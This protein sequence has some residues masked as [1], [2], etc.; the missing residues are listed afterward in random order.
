MTTNKGIT[1]VSKIGAKSRRLEVSS[2]DK[3][4]T[5]ATGLCAAEYILVLLPG[6]LSRPGEAVTA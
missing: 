3:V 6:T 2:V 1:F 5:Q 4:R